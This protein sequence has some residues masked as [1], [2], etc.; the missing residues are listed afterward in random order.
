MK[1]D[2]RHEGRSWSGQEAQ[3][4]YTLLPEKIEMHEGKLFWSDEERITMLALLLENIGV[5]RAVRIG[6]P[7]IWRKAVERV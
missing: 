2:I 7:E 1:W 3:Q 4:R 5:D 6:D